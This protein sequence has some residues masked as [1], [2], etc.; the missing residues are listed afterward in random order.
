[1]GPE[2]KFRT[3]GGRRTALVEEILGFAAAQGAVGLPWERRYDKV[4]SLVK[5]P[6]HSNRR[7]DTEGSRL[8]K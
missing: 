8:R 3:K 5:K 2:L 1:M 4:L 7:V 6:K